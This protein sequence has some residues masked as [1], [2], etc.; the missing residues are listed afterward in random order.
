MSAVDS[1]ELDLIDRSLVVPDRLIAQRGHWPGVAAC[2]LS[3]LAA[4]RR[5]FEEDLPD[6]SFWKTTYLF[7]M[8]W[9]T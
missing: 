2:S 9:W 5:V 6:A 4:Y 7:L 1:R 3:Q 8:T